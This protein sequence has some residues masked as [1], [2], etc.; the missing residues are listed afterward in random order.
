MNCEECGFPVYIDTRGEAIC[1]GCSLVAQSDIIDTSPVTQHGDVYLGPGGAGH[2]PALS[3]PTPAAMTTRPSMV[4]R[5]A[6]GRALKPEAA[7]RM[8]Y[9]T[10]VDARIVSNKERSAR[11][12]QVAVR[13]LANRLHAPPELEDRTYSVARKALDAKLFRGWDFGLVAGAAMHFALLESKG[14]VD[15][16]AFLPQ[17][18]VSHEATKLSNLRGAVR[19]IKRL[20]GVQPEMSTP[21]EIASEVALAF[22]LNGEVKRLLVA[23]AARLAPSPIPRIDAAALLY[24][25]AQQAGLGLTQ[26]EIAAACGTNDVS[27]RDRLD[28]LNEPSNTPAEIDHR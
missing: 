6:S 11:R 18:R 4:S 20:F 12:L 27:L 16:K 8:E 26:K 14:H 1:S 7:Q 25:S 24:V 10:K 17:V 13:D 3:V 28:R 21:L 19:E 22:G 15:L 23:N 9:L 2:G 5:D